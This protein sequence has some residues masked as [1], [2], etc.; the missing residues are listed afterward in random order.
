ML[1]LHLDDLK[2]EGLRKF[3]TLGAY[4]APPSVPTVY[5]V[6]DSLGQGGPP[7]DLPS[8][9]NLQNTRDLPQLLSQT[10]AFPGNHHSVATHVRGS[11]PGHFCTARG[12][13]NIIKGN[14]PS[15]GH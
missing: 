3:F 2:S 12:S 7:L 1:T 14:L 6:G 10:D 13:F 15:G 8:R 9:N 5:F 4:P 11:R